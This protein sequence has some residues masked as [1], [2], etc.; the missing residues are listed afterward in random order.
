MSD[1]DDRPSFRPRFDI[2]S[3]DAEGNEKLEVLSLAEFAERAKGVEMGRRGFLKLAL[4]AQAAGMAVMAGP[5]PA[6]SQQPSRGLASI[7]GVIVAVDYISDVA[8][9]QEAS[10]GLHWCIKVIPPKRAGGRAL[11]HV[12][13]NVRAGD[14]AVLIGP[15]SE[16]K[17]PKPYPVASLGKVNSVSKNIFCARNT[18][19]GGKTCVQTPSPLAAQ[20]LKPGAAAFFQEDFSI[21][22]VEDLPVSLQVIHLKTGGLIRC[23]ES[24]VEDDMIHYRV[25]Q[26]TVA[27]SLSTVDL[28][29]SF[30][31]TVQAEVEE[32]YA[33]QALTIGR[34]AEERQRKAAEEARKALELEKEAVRPTTPV[35]GSSK[36]PEEAPPARSGRQKTQTKARYEDAKE[37]CGSVTETCSCVPVCY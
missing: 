24:W 8:I 5:G 37:K 35:K 6:F 19:K 22:S 4:F 10:T 18:V 12:D 9:L 11:G 15:K 7:F 36:K 28:S 3:V 32:A 30:K 34:Q 14:W 25:G 17:S 26:G 13:K 31:A 2:K 1:S 23:E 20:T 21:N 16:L 27:L 33:R 29:R